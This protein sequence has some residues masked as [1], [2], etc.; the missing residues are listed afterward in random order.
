MSIPYRMGTISQASLS[1]A[2]SQAVFR[3]S[4]GKTGHLIHPRFAQKHPAPTFFARVPDA[5]P[6]GFAD[7]HTFF[8]V[9]HPL[10]LG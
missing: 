4:K 7:F 10:A 3:K 9:F 5:Q 6:A 2:F 1:W 8:A